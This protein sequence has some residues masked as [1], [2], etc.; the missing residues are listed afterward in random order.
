[1]IVKSYPQAMTDIIP[2][3]SP[4]AYDVATDDGNNNTR[5]NAPKAAPNLDVKRPMAETG[6]LHLHPGV[7]AVGPSR[8]AQPGYTQL[9]RV[10]HYVNP[11]TGEHVASLLPP[12]H[13]EMMCLQAGMHV[14]QTKYGVLGIL[15]AV[16]WFPLGIG[17]CILDRRV[18]CTR[19]GAIL[20][21]GLCN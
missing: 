8:S 19:C 17:L 6:P 10:H 11:S 1:M 15:A 14:P 18:K 16:F 2:Q 4:P 12:D 13:P 20:N 5:P 3:E 9:P 7:N 21:D